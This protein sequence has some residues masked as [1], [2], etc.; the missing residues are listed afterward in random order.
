MQINLSELPYVKVAMV[1]ITLFF[2]YR[3]LEINVFQNLQRARAVVAARSQLQQC[4]V[5]LSKAN[6]RV[7]ILTANLAKAGK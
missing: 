3:L 7:T 5:S 6:Q 1:V 4:N 2:G